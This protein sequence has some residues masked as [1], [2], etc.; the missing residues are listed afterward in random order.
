MRNFINNLIKYVIA[1]FLI[2]PM[3]SPLWVVFGIVFYG[4]DYEEEHLGIIR[5]VEE[6][7]RPYEWALWTF[8]V[9]GS[10]GVIYLAIFIFFIC[11]GGKWMDWWETVFEKLDKKFPTKLY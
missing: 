8:L 5:A 7:L 11:G 1:I 3:F 2:L 6:I 10:V 4:L 9:V